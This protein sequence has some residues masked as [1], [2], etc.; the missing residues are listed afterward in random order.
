MEEGTVSWL[1]VYYQLGSKGITCRTSWRAMILHRYIRSLQGPLK[2]LIEFLC[3]RGA[4]QKA[5]LI[6][7]L[8]YKLF[9]NKLTIH[10]LKTA[11]LIMDCVILLCTVPFV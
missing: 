9:I 11:N 4:Y 2:A 8:L 7:I 5:D 3:K 6:V 10:L 1:T